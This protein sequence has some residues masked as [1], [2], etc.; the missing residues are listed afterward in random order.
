MN[1]HPATTCP[2]TRVMNGHPGAACPLGTEGNGQARG[3]EGGDEWPALG[4]PSTK[5]S[6]PKDAPY[7]PSPSPR[8]DGPYRVARPV[9]QEPEKPAGTVVTRPE[10]HPSKPPP[11]TRPPS[12]PRHLHALRDVPRVAETFGWLPTVVALACPAIAY[13]F[14]D[15]ALLS[16]PRGVL[17]F[18][19][20]AGVIA[21][22]LFLVGFEVYRRRTRT[23]LAV[24]RV[25]IGIY[26]KGALAEV[27]RAGELV[28][29]RLRVTNTLRQ[30]IAAL[31]LPLAGGAALLVTTHSALLAFGGAASWGILLFASII[32]T[33]ITGRR[34]LVPK[35]AGREEILVSRT[36]GELLLAAQTRSLEARV[37]D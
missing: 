16:R 32:R 11:Q 31:F 8:V 20:A 13:L 18:L 26:R 23:V 35:E 5:M 17:D 2:L 34:L 3:E 12:F 15:E 24:D 22:G 37:E 7:F 9:P 1:G 27:I 33:R 36:D 25:F 30:L 21:L 29:Y 4:V 6:R 28:E 19:K 14:L 10:P